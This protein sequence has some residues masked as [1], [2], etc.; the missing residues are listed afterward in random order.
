V[1]NRDRTWAIAGTVIEVTDQPQDLDVRRPFT[2]ADAIAAGIDP[3]LLRGK[4]FR[5]IFKGVYISAEVPHSPLHR[6]EAA[7]VL[8]PPGAFASHASAARVY[9]LPIPHS[10]DE[11]VTVFSEKDRRRRTGIRCHVVPRAPRAGRF[12]GIRVSLPIPMFVELAS[13]L[14]L[15]DLVIVGDALVRRR[16]FTPDELVDAC[17]ASRDRHARAALRAAVL[18]RDGVDSPMETRLR[19]LL[20]LAGLPEPE[21]NHLVIDA[22]GRVVR[23]FDLSYPQHKL[24]VEYDGRQHAE[25]PDQY[26]SDIYRREQL[27]DWGWRIVVV[28][29]KGIFQRPEETLQRVRAAL[30]TRGATGLP[31]HFEDGWR[32]HFPVQQPFHRSA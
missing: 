23:R 26:S 10:A 21:V 30:R 14:S 31:T 24:I 25:D 27:D 19:L 29:V 28:T 13:I 3:R 32:H 5:K 8:H 11:H 17:R 18:V 2:R 12:K 1:D 9:N 20:V 16:A 6:V 15:V 4:R 22:Y 7:V